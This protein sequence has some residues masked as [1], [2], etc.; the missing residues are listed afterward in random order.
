MLCKIDSRELANLLKVSSGKVGHIPESE[1]ICR[2]R[3]SLILCEII[4]AKERQSVL[5]TRNL[6]TEALGHRGHWS[7]KEPN[8]EP[9]GAALCHRVRPLLPRGDGERVH[10][11]MAS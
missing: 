11:A 1:V 8:W 3:T 7:M 6:L 9:E 5:D 4:N 10:N 2:F